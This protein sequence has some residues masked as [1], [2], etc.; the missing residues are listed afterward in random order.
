M[1]LRSKDNV[2]FVY[3]SKPS[4][5]YIRALAKKNNQSMSALVD[6]LI[7]QNIDLRR[8]KTKKQNLTRRSNKG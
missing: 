3:L 8:V 2:L 4:I 5:N 6:N 1:K 7:Y